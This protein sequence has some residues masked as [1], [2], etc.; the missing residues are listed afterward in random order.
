MLFIWP[1]IFAICWYFFGFE[2]AIVIGF[3]YLHF[4][5]LTL[6]NYME[7]QKNKLIEIVEHITSKEGVD[8]EPLTNIFTG[9]KL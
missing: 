8:S 6:F 9:E 2:I 1:I 4:A 3:L 5:I 7:K